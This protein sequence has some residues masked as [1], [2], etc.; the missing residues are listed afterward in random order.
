MASLNVTTTLSEDA[1]LNQPAAANLSDG[2][3]TSFTARGIIDAEASL[4]GAFSPTLT[5]TVIF[6]Q[7]S[8]L[9]ITGAFTPVLTANATL[10]GETAL[11]VSSAFSITPTHKS[12]L[13]YT[14]PSPRD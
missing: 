4:T 3:T 8:T 6:D 10:S 9:T 2:F 1:A 11:S 13:L 7:P 12:C 14:S 5:D